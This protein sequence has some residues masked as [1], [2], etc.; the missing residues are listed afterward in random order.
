MS[1]N[2]NK[3][4]VIIFF[5]FGFF[6]CQNDPRKEIEI[7]YDV[8]P[9]IIA[10]D[11]NLKPFIVPNIPSI[12]LEKN[13]TLSE[14]Y[15][16]SDSI[17]RQ[18]EKYIQNRID[19]YGIA[20]FINDSL[21][22]IDSSS[23]F[24]NICQNT[25]FTDDC[26]EFKRLMRT[27]MKKTCYLDVTRLSPVPEYIF[28]KNDIH[29]SDSTIYQGSLQLSR[30]YFSKNKSKG[31]FGLFYKSNNGLFESERFFLIE[32]FSDGWIVYWST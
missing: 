1:R 22:A 6:S 20:L 26:I 7:Y 31:C 2:I 27:S 9:S 32:K 28:D 15:R 23:F 25:S 11:N 10:N 16:I 17:L 29:L 19:E 24:I 3:F 5:V 4:W 30:I 21:I 13:A 14:Y 12:E 8:L 18:N